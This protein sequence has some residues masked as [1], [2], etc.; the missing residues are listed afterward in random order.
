MCPEPLSAPGIALSHASTVG[1]W[2]AGKAL[3]PAQTPLT[4]TP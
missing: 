4:P 2:D 1:Q 3:P